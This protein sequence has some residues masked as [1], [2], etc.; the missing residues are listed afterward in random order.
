[1][2]AGH[3]TKKP[4]FSNMG[5]ISGGKFVCADFGEVCYGWSDEHSPTAGG[6]SPVVPFVGEAASSFS[7]IASARVRWG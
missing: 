6:T 7:K 1:M 5:I 4:Y 3:D 2:I